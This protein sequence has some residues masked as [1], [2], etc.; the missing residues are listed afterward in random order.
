MKSKLKI[1]LDPLPLK[2]A[3]GSAIIY[4]E[5]RYLPEEPGEDLRE[6][7]DM[8]Q[9]WKRSMSLLLSGVLLLSNV[10]LSALATEESPAPTETVVEEVQPV[11]TELVQTQSVEIQPIENQS[12]E[13]QPVVTVLEHTAEV[14]NTGLES[15]LQII[16]NGNPVDDAWLGT[17]YDEEQNQL[18]LNAENLDSV[19]YTEASQSLKIVL[20]EG[21]TSTISGALI[22]QMGIQITGKGTLIVGSIDAGENLEIVDAVV[23][24]GSDKQSEEETKN[25][26][27]VKNEIKVSGEA[28]LATANGHNAV[29]IT[30]PAKVD[31]PACSLV[32]E[33]YYR[34]NKTAIFAPITEGEEKTVKVPALYFEFVGKGHLSD[35]YNYKSVTGHHKTCADEVC[36]MRE[37]VQ[38]D[39]ATHSDTT[40][41][42]FTQKDETYHNVVCK[43]CG[44]VLEVKAHE[45]LSYSVS[46]DGAAINAVCGDC[47]KTGSVKITAI[48]VQEDDLEH[49][50]S[51][52]KTG[53][54][55][56]MEVSPVYKDDDDTEL[57][58]APSA[59]GKY[60][61][62]ITIAGKTASAE[63]YI[64]RAIAE[65]DFK[66]DTELPYTGQPQEPTVELK[67]P[68]S[69]IT[70]EVVNDKKTDAG[71]YQ[72]TVKGTGKYCKEIS[73]DY[74]ITKAKAELSET[75]EET[76]YIAGGAGGGAFVEPK[77]MIGDEE[78]LGEFKYKVYNTTATYAENATYAQASA[79]LRNPSFDSEVT[80]E[81]EFKPSN[82]ENVESDDEFKGN[83]SIIVKR[84]DFADSDHGELNDGFFKLTDD[85]YYGDNPIAT[86]GIAAFV[87]NQKVA[88]DGAYTVTY[89]KSENGAV[90]DTK[91]L[92]AGE[93]RAEITYSG[94]AGNVYCKDYPVF[95]SDT[96]FEIKPKPIQLTTVFEDHK[97][98][99]LTETKEDGTLVE[100][101]LID[102][103]EVSV[104]AA[105]AKVEYWVDGDAANT[106]ETP[107][108]RSAAGRYKVWYRVS[109]D[110]YET[111]TDYVW[112]TIQPELTAIYGDTLADVEGVPTDGKWVWAKNDAVLAQDKLGE[113]SVGHYGINNFQMVYNNSAPFT[114]KINVGAKPVAN[115]IIDA[116][117]YI[118]YNDRNSI[119]VKVY[120]P[121]EETKDNDNTEISASE[122]EAKIDEI[123][124]R[125]GWTTI[126]VR[127]NKEDGNYALTTKTKNILL[128]RPYHVAF[129]AL[130]SDDDLKETDF[131]TVAKV[132]T[133]LSSK[134]RADAY[135]EGTMKY[136]K[137][138]MTYDDTPTDGKENWIASR[139]VKKYYPKGGFTYV[140]PYSVIGTGLTADHDF[141]MSVMD[142]ATS[143]DLETEAGTPAVEITNF[144]KTERGIKFHY[145]G[146]SVVCIAPKVDL[147]KTYAIKTAIVYDGKTSTKGSLSIKVDNKTASAATYGQSV[148]ITA[149]ANSG[150]SIQSVK[151][152]DS[153]SKTV[154]TNQSGSKYTFK[155]PASDVTVKLTL[156]K[157]TSNT[158]NPYSGDTSNIYLWLAILASSAV[159]I[160]ALVIFWFKKRR[161]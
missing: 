30:D 134:I 8:K 116:A 82:A 38:I 72:L 145:D 70:Y 1:F 77:Y 44:Y 69:G 62:S 68:E 73:L 64:Q 2:K 142:A 91:P 132:K 102:T 147:T 28:H 161:K 74:A 40:E 89:K 136:F 153:S 12:V 79:A 49:S 43:C 16:Q 4:H 18:T 93:Y 20:E 80:V 10:P 138:M 111:K 31:N 100:L 35:E 5:R 99:H 27:K 58:K 133:E 46:T 50:A 23:K 122:Y 137:I 88:L 119:T 148:E 156:K 117:T 160:V 17:N 25:L 151:V 159:G 36:P 56:E 13:T 146:Y 71:S 152:T 125:T 3:G 26:I 53:I 118:H 52:E 108:K 67:N 106:T 55:S 32:G 75:L 7:T 150:Y 83:F 84:V 76:Q 113:H 112:T 141:K 103:I 92:P 143:T 48:S 120:D 78:L 97:G 41:T 109:A 127:D 24:V 130:Q 86:E 101:A 34:D 9:I 39:S 104:P 96:I 155:M 21:T 115:P 14:A 51:L 110:N 47:G 154:T 85:H 81:F 63:Y 149:G 60:T 19:S 139:D 15:K 107:S 114:V 87:D 37:N 129:S 158:K 98:K 121:V 124:S 6:V 90:V 95:S 140:I 157:T 128:Y 54:L 94:M 29:V 123:A 65:T 135:P 22:A 66:W 61:A 42:S 57:S 45:N 33:G 126:T 144:E 131:D 105:G 59:F 11:E